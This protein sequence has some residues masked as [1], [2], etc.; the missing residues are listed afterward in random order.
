M[1]KNYGRQY[2]DLNV[3]WIEKMTQTTHQSHNYINRHS[4]SRYY[5][6]HRRMPHAPGDPTS[7]NQLVEFSYQNRCYLC[8]V[9]QDASNRSRRHQVLLT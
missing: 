7:R 5:Q 4:L 8:A 9:G 3:I 1:K 6:T 2:S